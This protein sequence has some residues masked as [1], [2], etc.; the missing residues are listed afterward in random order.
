MTVTEYGHTTE[1]ARDVSKP[2][3][4]RGRKAVLGSSENG[5]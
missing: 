4:R 1:R 5:A 3:H 2:E